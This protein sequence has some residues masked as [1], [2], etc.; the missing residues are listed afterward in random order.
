MKISFFSTLAALR[1]LRRQ[2]PDIEA[3]APLIHLL[4]EAEPAPDLFARIEERLDDAP[5]PAKRMPLGR[6][7]FVFLCGLLAG[8]LA[9]FALQDRQSIFL[10]TSADGPWLPLGAVTLHGSGL[11]GLM[12]AECQG[13]T[14][15]F[16]A[17][18]GHPAANQRDQAP[19]DVPLTGDEEKIRMECIF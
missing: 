9:V 5:Q 16:I 15:F 12:R 13:Y 17:M 14:H 19:A 3:A 10:R 6:V 1:P 18:H 8:G 4:D 2:R 7:V 11:R